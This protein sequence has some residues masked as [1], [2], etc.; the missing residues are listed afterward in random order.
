MELPTIEF[1]V[2]TAAFAGIASDVASVWALSPEF[3]KDR[4]R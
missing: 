1:F 4:N 2:S 3:G